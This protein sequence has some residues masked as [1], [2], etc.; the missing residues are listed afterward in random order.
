MRC[1]Q[2]SQNPVSIFFFLSFSFFSFFS[3]LIPWKRLARR[4]CSELMLSEELSCLWRSTESSPEETCT[5]PRNLLLHGKNSESVSIWRTPQAG[6]NKKEKKRK[7]NEPNI[8]MVT[9]GRVVQKTCSHLC[10]SLRCTDSVP[11]GTAA[12]RRKTKGEKEEE[13]IYLFTSGLWF[14]QN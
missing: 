6:K 14:Q 5:F 2:L 11:A 10:I 7:C 13:E 9:T 3:F 4:V 8:G 12:G 1:K